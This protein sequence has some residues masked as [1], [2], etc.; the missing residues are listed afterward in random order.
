[1]T[2]NAADYSAVVTLRDGCRAEIRAL[3][4]SDEADFVAA[5]RRIGA[6]SLYNR[7]F[8]PKREF[9]ATE[10]AFFVNVDFV[11]HVALIAE[12]DEGER[13]AIVGGGRYVVVQPGTAELAFAIVDEYQ[14]RGVGTA[15]MC[16]LIALARN[17]GLKE[18]AADVLADNIA[19]MTVFQRSGLRRSTARRG[20]FV[21]VT[22]SL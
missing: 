11:T 19:M 7:F 10:I 5:V 4:A 17:A 22:L 8:G 3:K 12:V 16:H 1:L 9:S 2:L 15:L 18:L 20:R 6:P 21:R 13:S 14:G